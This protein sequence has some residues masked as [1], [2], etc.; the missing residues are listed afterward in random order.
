MFRSTDAERFEMIYRKEEEVSNKKSKVTDVEQ[1]IREDRVTI[2]Y[3]ID[4]KDPNLF[5]QDDAAHESFE[6]LKSYSVERLDCEEFFD[7]KLPLVILRAPKGTGK[8]TLCRLLENRLS[9]SQGHVSIL[10]F[11]SQIS[12][13]LKQASL[14]EWIRAWKKSIAEAILLSLADREAFVTDSDMIGIIE[15]AEKLGYKQKNFVG[16]IRDTFSISFVKPSQDQPGNIRDDIILKRVADRKDSVIWV[17]LDEVDQFFTLDNDSVLKV[18][19]MIMAAREMT[20]LIK[21][22]TIRITIKP[23]VLSILQ[24][25]IDTMANTRQFIVDLHWTEEFIR[26]VLARRIESYIERNNLTH[27]EGDLPPELSKEQREEWFISQ[28]FLTQRFDLGRGNRVPHVIL[29]S[30]GFYRPRWVIEL[31]R[32]CAKRR[33]ILA[34]RLIT[35]DD[36]K[37]SL[38]EFGKNRIKDLSSEYQSQ[39]T[40]VETIL[41]RFTGSRS[42]FSNLSHL[43]EFI[44]KKITEQIK[45]II[46]GVSEAASPREIARFLHQIGFVEP[47]KLISHG[48]YAFVHFHERPGLIDSEA[49]DDDNTFIWEIHQ[50]FRDAL[51]ISRASNEDILIELL[52]KDCV[53]LSRKTRKVI[54]RGSSKLVRK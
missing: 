41:N 52:P 37:Q 14:A 28:L 5:G 48:K 40:Q 46:V 4:Y 25:K 49:F 50:S 36:I 23:N 17:F 20:S 15:R 26:S 13:I 29:A 2:G 33:G 35:I 24:G 7:P 16:L 53:I 6:L 42:A 12:P 27:I 9:Q 1:P 32:I 19:A 21:D 3:Q 10:R 11:D 8:T 34:G 38:D 44:K 51:F 54:S 22:L 30:L 43:L 31:C 39:C 45:I 47:K 18:A